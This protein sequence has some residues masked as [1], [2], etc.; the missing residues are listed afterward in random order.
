MRP[1]LRQGHGIDFHRLT[2]DPVR[3]LM[4]GGLALE[5]ELAL[6]GHSDADVV[7]HA[8][9]DAMLGALAQGDIG[10]LFPDTDQRYK[11][12]DS[13]LIVAE[14]LNRVQIAGY[15]LANIDLTL[16]GEV[17]RIKPHRLRIRERLAQILSL[18]LDCI[19]LKATTTETMGALGRKEG[20]G[21][22]ATVLLE[23]T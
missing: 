12:M 17:P 5:S 4:L 20:V 13:A 10:D 7:L 18:P 2:T 23:A 15:R 9:A 22:M 16:I 14:A 8:L 6:V 21:C 19:S 11:N 3:P 1:K